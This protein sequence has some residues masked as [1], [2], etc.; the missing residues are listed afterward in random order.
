[1]I[2]AI[3]PAET[4]ALPLEIRHGFLTCLLF[5]EVG[6]RLSV[7]ARVG[8]RPPAV[9]ELHMTEVGGEPSDNGPGKLSQRPHVGD[10]DPN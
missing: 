5:R 7:R 8:T 6:R 1:V 10:S 3:G 2:R 9:N 4:I